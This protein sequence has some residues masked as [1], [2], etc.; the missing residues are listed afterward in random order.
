MTAQI[1]IKPSVH[2]GKHWADVVLDGEVRRHGPF[3]DPDEAEVMAVRLA[4]MCRAMNAEVHM[5]ATAK[6]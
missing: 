5:Q 1:D 2:D 6:G 4:A 3:P